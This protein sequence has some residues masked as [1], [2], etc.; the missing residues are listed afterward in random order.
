MKLCKK[1]EW[2]IIA[3][4]NEQKKNSWTPNTVVVLNGTI[5]DFLSFPGKIPGNL[6]NMSK[7]FF[8]SL[9]W[10]SKLLCGISFTSNK[11]ISMVLGVRNCFMDFSS[12]FV[13]L[14]AS[15]P[16]H[17]CEHQN[18]SVL[19]FLERN[20]VIISIA[21]PQIGHTLSNKWCFYHLGTKQAWICG[22]MIYFEMFS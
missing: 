17:N 10:R 15:F 3:K 18:S 6:L 22:H 11:Q 19:L 12:S 16:L 2:S 14:L 13:F 20:S 21:F 5:T 9:S 4:T 1:G 7:I 8:I